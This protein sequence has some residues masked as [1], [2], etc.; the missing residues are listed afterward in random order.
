MIV[1][2]LYSQSF[3]P[4]S[5][6]HVHSKLAIVDDE[7]VLCGSANLVDLSMDLNDE[8]HTEICAV[9]KD[10][11]L[12][13]NLR[14]ELFEEHCGNANSSFDEFREKA[15][16]NSMKLL[17]KCPVRDSQIFEMS[18]TAFGEFCMPLAVRFYEIA[19]SN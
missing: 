7:I 11:N 16:E 10:K 19:R 6:I 14:R 2:S 8:L 18:P 9:I 1:A 4:S 17:Q 3:F 12:A 15:R 5:T 13:T